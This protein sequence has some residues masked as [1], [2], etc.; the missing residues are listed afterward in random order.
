MTVKI[1]SVFSI[2]VTHA[3]GTHSS[4]WQMVISG[5]FDDIVDGTSPRRNGIQYFILFP[6]GI[7][8]NVQCQ[9]M[10]ALASEVGVYQVDGGGKVGDGEDSEER[11]EYFVLHDFGVNCGGDDSRG[12][13]F[14]GYVVMFSAVEYLASGIGG[15]MFIIFYQRD[16][17]LGMFYRD[18]R[19]DISKSTSCCIFLSVGGGGIHAIQGGG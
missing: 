18:H 7:G 5:V 3:G 8:E 15:G 13:E 11:T 16:N 1:E 14:I 10:F 4:E 19:P 9:G 12:N 17:A 2:P 6:F